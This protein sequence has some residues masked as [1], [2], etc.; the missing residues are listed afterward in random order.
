[1]EHVA[2]ASKLQQNEMAEKNKLSSMFSQASVDSV[3]V[4]NIQRAHV[5]PNKG[6][7][8]SGS[9]ISEPSGHFKLHAGTT[10]SHSHQAL[11]RPRSV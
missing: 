1:M 9:G 10:P 8:F 6:S 4:S 2:G 3:D 5:S 7:S 11:A